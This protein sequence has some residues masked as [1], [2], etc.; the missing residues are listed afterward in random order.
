MGLKSYPA[1]FPKGDHRPCQTLTE[2]TLAHMPRDGSHGGA[3]MYRKGTMVWRPEDRSDSIFFLLR[4]QVAMFVGDAAGREVILR[5]VEA[6]EPFGELCFCGGPTKTRQT[7][8]RAVV[9]IEAVEIKLDVFMNYLRE[10]PAVL[11]AFVFTFCSRL[12]DAERRIEVLA[13]RGAMDRLGWLLVHLANTRGQA[14]A[15][16]SG[17]VAV[18]VSH[19]ELARMAAM[20]RS[21]VTVTMGR[22]RRLGLVRYERSRPLFVDV[23][24]LTAYLSSER[25]RLKE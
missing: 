4:G 2:L 20:S 14:N 17:D 11:A 16:R 3:R 1:E 12:A 9:A 13:H 19:E 25:R 18:P 7:N 10:N 6:G 15:G 24:K 5:V 21:H 22:L 8:V 23:L